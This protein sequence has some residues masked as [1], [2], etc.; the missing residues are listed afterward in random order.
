MCA[1]RSWWAL[2]RSEAFLDRADSL[3]PGGLTVDDDRPAARPP[4]LRDLRARKRV[5]PLLRRDP[6]AIRRPR[7][8]TRRPCATG[9]G[10]YG[11][12]ERVGVEAVPR[13]SSAPPASCSLAK[14]TAAAIEPA[15]TIPQADPRRA[16]RC[17][18]GSSSTWSRTSVRSWPTRGSTSRCT[19][20]CATSPTSTC[21]PTS[22]SSRRTRSHCWRRTSRSSSRTWWGSTTRWP[23]SCCGVS[24]RPTSAARRSASSGTCPAHA[25]SRGSRRSRPKESLL[26]IP[27][28]HRWPRASKLGDHDHREKPGDNEQE[29]VLVIRGELLKKYPTAIIY[30]HKARVG[31]RRRHR[32][33]RRTS[34]SSS[35]CTP[36]RRPIPPT[37]SSRRRC[38]R[39]ACHPTSRSSDST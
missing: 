2:R 33:T 39:R 17:R 35:S 24:T 13:P 16:S 12:S 30:A 22:T 23:A 36:H 7:C 29:A 20:R 31:S 11:A 18:R 6:A 38:T 10:C 4:R 5:H 26:D 9:P 14:G 19:S 21:C 15:V 25:R 3:R 8:G 32:R 34:A 27:E 37:T 28:L 1:S